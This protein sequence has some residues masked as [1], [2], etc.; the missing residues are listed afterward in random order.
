M[1]H[2]R[3]FFNLVH[4][5]IFMSCQLC[6]QIRA[7]SHSSHQCVHDFLGLGAGFCFLPQQ[8]IHFLLLNY[9]MMTSSS[10]LNNGVFTPSLA[11]SYPTC[12]TSMTFSSTNSTNTGALRWN[13]GFSISAAF[14]ACI[15]ERATSYWVWYSATWA[16][17]LS[18]YFSSSSIVIPSSTLSA[19]SPITVLQ[20]LRSCIH[21][22]NFLHIRVP[23]CIFCR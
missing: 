14:I 16:R 6:N 21:D 3:F 11:A 15:S 4:V 17:S 2:V 7:S 9:I 19:S 13:V 10:R 1:R 12:S 8:W 23:W 5:T 18:S 22:L 20:V